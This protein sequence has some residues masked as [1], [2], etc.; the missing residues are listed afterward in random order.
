MFFILFFTL[1]LGR[2][3]AKAECSDGSAVTSDGG[4]VSLGSSRIINDIGIGVSRAQE[5]SRF[6]E[7][8][9]DLLIDSR[10]VSLTN[11]TSSETLNLISGSY[12]ISMLNAS[13][14]L[15]KISIGGESGTINEAE[16]VTI[17]GLY[18][19]LDNAEESGPEGANVKLVIGAQKLSLSEEQNPSEK[20][21]VGNKSFVIELSS[22]SATNALVNVYK[23]ATGDIKEAAINTSEQTTS[24]NQTINQTLALNTTENVTPSNQSTNGTEE[25][26]SLSITTNVS[27]NA[28]T[29]TTINRTESSLP[30]KKEGFFR[31]LISWLMSLFD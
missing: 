24:N 23:C 28:A 6:R 8:Y 5:G 11:I 9:A 26:T 20:I 30:Q 12:T 3:S 1:G 31:R 22:A 2:I 15:A 10:R 21:T 14:S 18:V 4:E 17:K 16:V 25:N 13:S 27:Q 19:Y 29:N 7:F